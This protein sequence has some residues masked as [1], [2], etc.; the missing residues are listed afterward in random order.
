MRLQPIS[1]LGCLLAVTASAQQ[2]DVPRLANGVPDLNGTWDNG[3]GIDFINPVIDGASICLSGCAAPA[4][5]GAPAAA[6]L[7]PDRPR[8]RPEYQAR[9]DDLNARQ[10]EFDPVLRCFAPG[11]PRIGPPDKIVQRESE[12]VFLYDDVSGNFFRIVPIDAGSHPD[13]T[14]PSYLGDAIGWWEGDTL[15]VE[16]V[17]FNGETWLTDDGSFHTPD[18][19]VVERIRRDGDTLTWQA[20][21][22]DPA[23]LAEPWQLRERVAVLTDIEVVEAPPCIER[24]LDHMVDDSHHDN[25]R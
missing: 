7:P 1:I 20:T 5:A 9:V 10:V 2:A 19:R 21:A 4:D 23:V 16:T 11:V 12:V 13:D 14:V 25:P 8:Y 6:P 22:Y 24:D 17:N 18:L 15:V 3:S